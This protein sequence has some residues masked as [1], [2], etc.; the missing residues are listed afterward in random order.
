M[1][2]VLP[3]LESKFLKSVLLN[4]TTVRSAKVMTI[5]LKLVNFVALG[6]FHK[7]ECVSCAQLVRLVLMTRELLVAI[8]KLV[9]DVFTVEKAKLKFHVQA[10]PIQRVE[11]MSACVVKDLFQN[12]VRVNAVYVQMAPVSI[13]K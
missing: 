1:K 7:M 11:V 10:T 5:N 6:D 9:I 2:V 12:Q 8:A 3:V 4:A 13:K